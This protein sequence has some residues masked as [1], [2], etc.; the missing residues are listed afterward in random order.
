MKTLVYAILCG[1]CLS[2]VACGECELIEAVQVDSQASEK[3]E[4]VVCD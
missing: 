2:L 3:I 1:L 4:V